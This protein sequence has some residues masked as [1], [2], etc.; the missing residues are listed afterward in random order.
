MTPGDEPLSREQRRRNLDLLSK[1]WGFVGVDADAD[2]ETLDRLDDDEHAQWIHQLL[3][4]PDDEVGDGDADDVPAEFPPI[5][6]ADQVAELVDDLAPDVDRA[7]LAAINQALDVIDDGVEQCA[8]LKQLARAPEYESQRSDILRKLRS[9]KSS[10]FSLRSKLESRER[11]LTA[12]AGTGQGGF[13]S[14]GSGG[15]TS[16]GGGVDRE[17]ERRRQQEMRD[18]QRSTNEEILKI[19]QGIIDSRRKAMERQHKEFLK[20]IQGRRW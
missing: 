10:I 4:Q 15:F 17:A 2:E 18:L 13:G 8:L 6:I 3:D 1:S 12:D 9:A 7:G 5:T 16:W 14:G 11:K 19:H 20:Y